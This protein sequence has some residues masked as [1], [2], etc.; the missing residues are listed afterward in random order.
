MTISC[1]DA[2]NDDNGDDDGGHSLRSPHDAPGAGRALLDEVS[3][4]PHSSG[5]VPAHPHLAESEPEALSKEG[6][7]LPWLRL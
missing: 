1:E 6:F 7:S 5:L 4:N 3:M 2:A